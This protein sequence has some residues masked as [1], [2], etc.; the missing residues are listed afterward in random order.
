VREAIEADLRE[1]LVTAAAA[2]ENHPAVLAMVESD[3]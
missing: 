1:G 3:V 2:R